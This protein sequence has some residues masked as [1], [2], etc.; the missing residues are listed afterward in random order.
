M[1]GSEWR[2]GALFSYVDLE[3]RVRRDHPL[4][5]IRKLV[6]A[7][8]EALSGKRSSYTLMLGLDVAR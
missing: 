1:R 5:S 8:L 4:R 7:A 6:D 2:S 3:D